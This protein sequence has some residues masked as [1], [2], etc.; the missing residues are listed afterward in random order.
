[1]LYERLAEVVKNKAMF[2]YLPPYIILSLVNNVR[3]N[4]LCYMYHSSTGV[5][6]EFTLSI[7]K[8]SVY[9]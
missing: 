3:C 2:Y 4:I 5:D 8:R 9:I 1:M 6:A 7:V